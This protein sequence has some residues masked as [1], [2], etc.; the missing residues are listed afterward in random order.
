M[1]TVVTGGGS[2]EGDTVVTDFEGVATSGQWTLG[3]AA[4]LQEV[5]AASGAAQVTFRAFAGPHPSGL[6]GQIA[7]VSLA[8][9]SVEIAVVN[10]DGSGFKRMK[11]PGLDLQPAWSPDGSQIA[12]VQGE[13]IGATAV[14]RFSVALMSADGVFLGRVAWAGDISWGEVLDPGS[15]TWSPDGQIIAYSFVDASRVRSVKYV[16]LDE[17]LVDHP[18][19]FGPEKCKTPVTFGTGLP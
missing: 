14:M 6:E 15:L 10:A 2:I 8:D 18:E 11:H 13:L 9:A 5:K 3:A 7:F 17:G 4:G 1:F 12:F 16:S 19:A